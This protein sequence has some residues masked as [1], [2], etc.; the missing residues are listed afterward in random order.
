[1][2]SQGG[3]EISSVIGN[4]PS[5]VRDHI[6]SP[7]M[8]AKPCQCSEGRRPSSQRSQYPALYQHLKRRLGRSLRAR[9]IK[10]AVV[11]QGEKPTHKCSR[12][13]SGLP[14]P[15]TSVQNTSVSQYL[16]LHVWPLGVNS[17][18]NKASLW[19]WQRELL[20]L[21]DH[22]QGPSTNQSGLF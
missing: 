12:T 21:K 16:N 22:Q 4:P 1:M 18:K 11:R 19:K 13:E 7:R 15:V 14:T 10:R 9:L 2:A 20:P 5:L 17:S 8:V 6:S 3:L